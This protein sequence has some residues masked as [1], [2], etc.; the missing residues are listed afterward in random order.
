VVNGLAVLTTGGCAAKSSSALTGGAIGVVVA[1]AG[2]SGIATVARDGSVFCSFDA[3][4]TVVGD[5]VVPSS[6]STGGFFYLCH[7]AG[8]TQPS[9]IQVLGR[10]LQASSGSSTV[11]MF[12]GMPGSNVSSASAGTGTCTNQ[13]VTAVNSGSPTCT[14]ITSAYVNSSIPSTWTL[15]SGN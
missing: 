7:D 10:V 6:T 15:V 9:G 12:L 14:T 5:Y 3:T 4:P 2:I 13:V 8:A 1:N 11:Q